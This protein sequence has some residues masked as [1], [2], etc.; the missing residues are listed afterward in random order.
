MRELEV[1]DQFAACYDGPDDAALQAVP[2]AVD[3]LVVDGPALGRPFVD[4]LQ[5]S[6]Y[7]NMKE[8]RPRGGHLRVLFAFDPCRMAI[9]LLGGDKK[10]RWVE[11]YR[12]AI[13]AAD[14][15]YNA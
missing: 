11:W 14:D 2:E 6:R 1:T 9:L 7:P 4:T 10:G 3:G 12:T 5:T 13:P 15:L 8:L